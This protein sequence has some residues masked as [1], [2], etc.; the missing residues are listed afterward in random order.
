MNL[1]YLGLAV[2][3]LRRALRLFEA[4]GYRTAHQDQIS[5]VQF[6]HLENGRSRI[7]LMYGISR[8]SD[9]AGSVKAHGPGPYRLCYTVPDLDAAAATLET[10][11]LLGGRTFE[12]GEGRSWISRREPVTGLIIELL[13]SR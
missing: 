9:V 1:E 2:T 3:D 10:A 6:A 7:I 5:G 13:E 4:L 8:H 11:G 12:H